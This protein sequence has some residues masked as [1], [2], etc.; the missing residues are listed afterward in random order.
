MS[1]YSSSKY[2]SALP[3]FGRALPAALLL[4]GLGLLWPCASR[5]ETCSAG[6][7]RWEAKLA[8]ARAEGAPAIEAPE[9][10]AATLHRQPTA[11]SIANAEAEANAKAGETL[12]QAKKL[13]ADGKEREC[14]RPLDSLAL[15]SVPY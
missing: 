9:S 8:K 11:A 7:A 13:Q 4:G 6:I 1:K 12:E 15:E 5:A 10:T 3:D 2:R 14:V